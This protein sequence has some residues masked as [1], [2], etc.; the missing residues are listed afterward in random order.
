MHAAILGMNLMFS[1]FESASMPSIDAVNQ[2]LHERR[3]E[4]AEFVKFLHFRADFCL[5]SETP[6]VRAALI[7][8]EDAAA[9]SAGYP[10]PPLAPHRHLSNARPFSCSVLP[11]VL[12]LTNDCSGDSVGMRCA[13]VAALRHFRC[14]QS[15]PRF[16]FVH[17]HV[18]RY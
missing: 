5:A 10:P 1:G 12:H 4:R 15:C 3:I 14:S 8:F 11:K 6:D 9:R 7:R 17:L 2:L 18:C 16:R 13:P